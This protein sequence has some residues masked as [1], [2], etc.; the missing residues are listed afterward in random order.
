MDAEDKSSA[1]IFLLFQI[2]IRISLI[3]V[4]SSLLNACTVTGQ[5]TG[6]ITLCC[7]YPQ[8]SFR[9]LS[10]WKYNDRACCVTCARVSHVGH[11]LVPVPE[12][13]FHCQSQ[14]L[15]PQ[16]RKDDAILTICRHFSGIYHKRKCSLA[17]SS[18]FVP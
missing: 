12:S 16:S 17:S 2:H 9:C 15:V 14:D 18:I 6:N 13:P 10:C 7:L 5:C 4:V 11:V 1:S 3:N 8:D